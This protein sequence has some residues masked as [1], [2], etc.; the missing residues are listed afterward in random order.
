[1]TDAGDQ[2]LGTTL[3]VGDVI[4]Y[5]G[6]AEDDRFLVQSDHTLAPLSPLAW[7]LY[8]LGCGAKGM[9]KNFKYRPR[10][11]TDWASPRAKRRSPC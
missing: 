10:F 6:S 9:A 11:R 1:M 2:V 5:S 8:Q 3:R 7:Q 4:H